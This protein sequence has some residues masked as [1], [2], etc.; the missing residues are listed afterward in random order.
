MHNGLKIDI[1]IAYMGNHVP[2]LLQFYT[3]Y[4]QLWLFMNYTYCAGWIFFFSLCKSYYSK[5]S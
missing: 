4:V 5:I 1:F 3:I 2:Y